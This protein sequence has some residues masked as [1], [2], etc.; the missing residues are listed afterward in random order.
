MNG[1]DS[2]VKITVI[3]GWIYRSL[4]RNKFNIVDVANYG[5]LRKILTLDD[6]ATYVAANDRLKI[7]SSRISTALPYSNLFI[8]MSSEERIEYERSVLS[9]SETEAIA[10][11]MFNSLRGE[12]L[13]L[14]SMSEPLYKFISTEDTIFVIINEGFLSKIADFEFEFVKQYIKQC[15]S[16][17]PIHEVSKISLFSEYIKH[18]NKASL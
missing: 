6:L 4:L 2:Q 18:L 12:H 13:E 8:S 3:P 17:L 10:L 16:V 1:L 15:Y 14:N 11:T 7:N 5:K 9:L